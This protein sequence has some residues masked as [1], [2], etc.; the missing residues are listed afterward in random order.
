MPI[1]SAPQALPCAIS[2]RIRLVPS[3]AAVTFTAPRASS[4]VMTSGFSF[5]STALANAA[6]RILR[7]TSRVSSDMGVS[8]LRKED[9]RICAGAV[10]AHGEHTR[11]VQG[12]TLSAILDLMPARGTVGDDEC[13]GLRASHRGQQRQLGHFDRRIVGVSAIAE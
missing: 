3:C 12:C 8:L 7:A 9:L 1:A 13:A 6:S 10:E 2:A 4:T 11:D 5:F